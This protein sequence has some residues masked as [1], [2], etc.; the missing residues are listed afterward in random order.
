MDEVYKK[1]SLDA[2]ENIYVKPS[3]W[4]FEGISSEFEKHINR[5]VPLYDQ[6]HNLVTSLTDFF[7]KPNS[8]V[9]DIGC[10][11]GNL[12]SSISDRQKHIKGIN[13]YLIDEVSDMVEYAKKNVNINKFH[14]Y[15]FVCKDILR[16]D[17]PQ[18]VDIMISMFTIQFTAPSIRQQILNNI[19][20]SLAWGGGF[21]F[22]EKVNGND[23][24]FHDILSQNYEDFKILNGYTLEEIKTKKLSLRSI[25]KPFSTKGNLDLLKRA[26][27]QDIQPIFQ[28]GLFKGFLAIK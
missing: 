27:F 8:F 22:F 26:G 9:V 21:F 23:A 2:G 1:N 16:F 20:E 11:T 12:V 5:S 24:R 10:S 14:A 7:I 19:Y 18:N 4:S 13:F 28:Y 3:S 17:L 15:N 6:A 25:L